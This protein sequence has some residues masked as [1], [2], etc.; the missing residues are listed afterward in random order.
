V[1]I[2]KRRKHGKNKKKKEEGARGTLEFSPQR[3]RV[4]DSINS[5]QFR[6]THML[7][8]F[9]SHGLLS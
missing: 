6:C 5:M 1:L 9:T 2:C 8:N 4:D 7:V 3:P